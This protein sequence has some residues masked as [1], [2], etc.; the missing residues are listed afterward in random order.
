MQTAFI[1]ISVFIGVTG[2]RALFVYYR[3]AKRSADWMPVDGDLIECQLAEKYD[4]GKV[5]NLDVRY[6]YEVGGERYESSEI[7]FY[8]RKWSSSHRYYEQIERCIRDGESFRVYVDPDNPTQSVIIPGADNA[9]VPVL[10][11]AGLMLFVCPWAGLAA[12]Y[13]AACYFFEK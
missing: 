8:F 10:W 5:Y 12:F 1:I 7:M 11:L 6:S 4:E 13:M 9:P 2:S 3:K